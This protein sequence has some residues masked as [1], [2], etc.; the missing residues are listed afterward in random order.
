MICGVVVLN[1]A[2]QEWDIEM[3]CLISKDE[4]SSSSHSVGVLCVSDDGGEEYLEN[5]EVEF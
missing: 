5:V 4:S 1:E 2:M 3:I